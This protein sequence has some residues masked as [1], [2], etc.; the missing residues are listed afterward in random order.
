MSTYS[1]DEGGDEPTA[2]SATLASTSPKTAPE[3]RKTLTLREGVHAHAGEF[4]NNIKKKVG[5][6]GTGSAH[7][8]PLFGRLV[9]TDGATLYD[10]WDD[11][12]K[13][14]WR[15]NLVEAIAIITTL[16]YLVAGAVL[17]P[18]EWAAGYDQLLTSDALYYLVP[19]VFAA[20]WSTIT[21]I[22]FGYLQSQISNATTV[23]QKKKDQKFP[24]PPI[25]LPYAVLMAAL[26]IGSAAIYAHMYLSTMTQCQYKMWAKDAAWMYTPGIFGFVSSVFLRWL[27]GSTGIVHSDPRRDTI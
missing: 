23:A 18:M 8:V 19:A 17:L 21:A 3:P 10:A 13:N 1:D 22:F 20:T 25:F 16:I 5:P 15:G 6:V 26:Q 14:R 27:V 2:T 9:A 11:N 12:E 4:F 7:P 24:P